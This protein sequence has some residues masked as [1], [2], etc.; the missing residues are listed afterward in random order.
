MT[1]ILI[2]Y[3]KCVIYQNQRKIKVKDNFDFD[4][5]YKFWHK[6]TFKKY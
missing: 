3:L 4:T 1:R 2:F 5:W 6:D